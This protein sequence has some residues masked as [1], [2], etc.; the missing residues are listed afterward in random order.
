MTEQVNVVL[1]GFGWLARECTVIPLLNKYPGIMRVVLITSLK[2]GDYETVVIPTFQKYGLDI[3]EYIECFDAAIDNI[4][5]RSV[6]IHALIITNPNIFHFAQINKALDVGLHVYVDKPIA[7]PSDDLPFLVA[8]AQRKKLLLFTGI[9]R[10]LEAPYKYLY[11]AVTRNREFGKLSRIRCKLSFAQHLTDWRRSIDLAGG[12]ILI[13]S[14][15]HLLDIVGWIISSINAEVANDLQGQFFFGFDESHCGK[16]QQYIDVET[17][18]VGYLRLINLAVFIDFTYNAPD[19]SVHEEVE[20]IDIYNARIKI[21]REQISRSSL[22]AVV[23]H[24]RANGEFVNL[25][26]PFNQALRMDNVR[27]SEGALPMEPLKM[28]IDSCYKEYQE[29]LQGTEMIQAENSIMTWRLIRQIYRLAAKD[30]VYMKGT[31]E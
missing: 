20:V 3:P 1:S 6:K 12:G 26:V 15:Y 28:F 14:G 25:E 9:Q 23:T 21:R 22:P 10:R 19:G 17:E 30:N 29:A 5:Y 18:V 31:K 16:D 8:L 27:F 24:Q 13:D 7:L 2:A 11:S 4:Q